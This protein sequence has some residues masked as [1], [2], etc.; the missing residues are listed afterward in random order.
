M[1]LNCL[2]SF[3]KRFGRPERIDRKNVEKERSEKSLQDLPLEIILLIFSFNSA[4]EYV[5]ASIINKNINWIVKNSSEGESLW[6]CFCQQKSWPQNCE[7]LKWEEIYRKNHIF[8]KQMRSHLSGCHNRSVYTFFRRTSHLTVKGNLVYLQSDSHF[9]S[10]DSNRPLPKPLHSSETPI[11]QNNEQRID[12]NPYVIAKISTS[13]TYVEYANEDI[14]Q[15]IISAFPTM[16]KNIRQV[17]QIGKTFVSISN[18]PT[19]STIGLERIHQLDISQDCQSI[20]KVDL[21]PKNYATYLSDCMDCSCEIIAVALAAENEI[22]L[23]QLDGEKIGALKHPHAGTQTLVDWNETQPCFRKL[24][25]K[26]DLVAA[27][28]VDSQGELIIYVWNWKQE[29]LLY[30]LTPSFPCI[31]PLMNESDK[32]AIENNLLLAYI[33]GYLFV[34]NVSDGEN[35]GKLKI[36]VKCRTIDSLTMADQR[37]IIKTPN[38][39]HLVE[40]D[41]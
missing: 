2:T 35:M 41:P 21:N 10:L 36:E 24:L 23:Y 32:L 11:L 25:V 22:S 8:L 31:H 16:H 29:R 3:L 12:N 33:S 28:S 38:Q 37:I 40:F 34:W 20:L 17:Y 13:R 1:L 14:P 27:I 26:N 7:Q 15:K 18:D 9:H 30:A 5:K 4:T 39:L 6:K 19:R